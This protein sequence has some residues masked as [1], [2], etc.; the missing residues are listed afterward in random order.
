MNDFLTV[1]M[2]AYEHQAGFRLMVMVLLEVCL[3][4]RTHGLHDKSVMLAIDSG[5]APGSENRLE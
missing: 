3:H 2:I 5:E 4:A 1:R